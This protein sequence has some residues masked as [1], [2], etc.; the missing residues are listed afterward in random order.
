MVTK[1]GKKLGLITCTVI[2]AS[3]MM[4]SGIAMLPSSLA[5][6]GSITILSWVLAIV[7]ALGLAYIFAKLGLLDPQEGG[8]VAYASEVSPIFGFQAQTLFGTSLPNS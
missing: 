4:G 2:V 7:G 6:I 5:A 1:S 3:N 8:P